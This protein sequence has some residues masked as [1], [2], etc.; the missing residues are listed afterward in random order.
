MTAYRVLAETLEA[1]ANARGKLAKIAR[2][3]ETLPRSRGKSSPWPARL[4]SG[5]PVRGVRGS[6]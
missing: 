2:L 5:S 1:V 3:A 6:R 4:L